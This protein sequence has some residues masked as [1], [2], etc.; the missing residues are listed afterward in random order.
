MENIVKI[1]AIGTAVAATAYGV[2]N[3]LADSIGEETLASYAE[4]VMDG[5]IDAVSSITS[6]ID[7]GDV[8]NGLD[9]FIF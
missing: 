4:E 1:L 2:N 3:L 9:S 5:T 6:D 7:V 8:L